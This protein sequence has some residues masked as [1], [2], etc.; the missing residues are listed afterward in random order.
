MPGFEMRK[1]LERPGPIPC[2]TS[3]Q[4]RSRNF[5]NR[6]A[7]I[8]AKKIGGY[9]AK[10]RAVAV[11]V[12]KETKSPALGFLTSLLLLSGRFRRP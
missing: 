11:G 2:T 12:A 1:D 7:G 9:V 3:N 6:I 4:R 10:E 5:D 8:I